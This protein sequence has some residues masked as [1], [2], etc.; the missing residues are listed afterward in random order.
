ML[1][2]YQVGLFYTDLQDPRM[3]SSI[4]LTHSRFQPILFL[5]GIARSLFVLAH[6]GEI[7]T[8]RGAENWMHSHQIEVYDEENSDSAKLENCMEFLYR[9]GEIYLRR[10]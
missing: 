5:A 3:T 6:N 8:L 10:F 9:Q 7:N 2:A 1:H 4:A